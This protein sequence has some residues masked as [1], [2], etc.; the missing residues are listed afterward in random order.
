MAKKTHLP[1]VGEL[2]VSEDAEFGKLLDAIAEE[3]AAQDAVLKELVKAE[4]AA[5]TPL[6][7]QLAKDEAE[8]WESL[9]PDHGGVPKC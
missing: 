5:L 8:L 6:L 1:K 4:D 2:P 9:V 3:S 7:E